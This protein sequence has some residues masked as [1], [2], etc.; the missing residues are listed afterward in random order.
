MKHVFAFLAILLPASL[1]TLAAAEYAAPV[2]PLPYTAEELLSTRVR[3]TYEGDNLNLVAFPLGGIGA[4]CISLAGTGKLVD[5]E[6]F[7]QPNKG[8]QPRFSFLSVWAKSE[9]GQP[10]FKVLEGQLR[11]RLDGPVYLAK[12][13][14]SAGHGIG[15][16]QTQ[17]A[18]LPRMRQCTFIGRFPY[19]RVELSDPALPLAATIE[20]WSP[21]IPGN[22]RESSLPVA[23][24]SV[25][26]RNTSTQ[27]VEFA[28]AANVQNRAGTINEIVREDRFSALVMRDEPR[29][30]DASSMALAIPRQCDMWQRNW[31]P[32][33]NFMSLQHFVDTF[34]LQGRM[35]CSEPGSDLAGRAI[36]GAR[37]DVVFDDFEDG[38]YGKWQAQGEAFGNRP[39]RTNEFHHQQ[40]VGGTQ[41][42][43]FV[44]SF[45]NN[46][47][48]DAGVSDRVVGELVSKP[49]TINRS[50]LRFLIGGGADETSVGLRLLVDGK[51]VRSAAGHNSELLA[52]KLWD[53]QEFAGREAVLQIVDRSSGGWGHVLVDEIVL[54]DSSELPGRASDLGAGSPTENENAQVG[55]LGVRRVLAPGESFTLPMLVAWYFPKGP[56]WRN[57]YATQWKDAQDVARYVATNLNRLDAETR[58]FQQTFFDSTLPGTVLEAVSS[59]LA[60]L[61]SPTVIRLEDG[62]LYGWEGCAVNYRLGLGTVNHVW[63][64][65]Q[66]VP[67]LFPDLQRSIIENFWN[68]GVDER[69]K[70]AYRIPTRPGDKGTTRDAADGRNDATGAFPNFRTTHAAADGQFGQICWVYREW[71][72]SGDAA[73]L[74]RMWPT[75]KKALEY[76]WAVWDT[77]RDG[78]LDGSH[79]NTLDLN[80]SSPETMCGSL[81]QAAL[82]AGEKMAL[83][84]GDE[85]AAG[86]YRRVFE[87]GKRNSDEKLFNG[88][89]YQQMLPAPGDYQVGAGC[90]SEQVH[91]QLYAQM[92]GLEDIYDRSHIHSALGSLFKYNYCDN[93]HD[94]LN[95]NRAYAINEDRGLL[96]ATWPRGGKPVH[97]L[98]Y[99]DETQIGYEYQVAGNLLYE[100]YL[101]E[102]LTVIRSIR[103]RFDGK[104]RNP[105][106][107]FE[108]GNHY[109][110]SMANYNALLALSG[111]RTDAPRRRIEFAP[112]VT[113]ENF[114]GFFAAGD[115]WGSY[116]QRA[117][118]GKFSARLEM[119]SGTLRLN[120]ISLVAPA[121]VLEKAVVTAAGQ[122]LS[123]RL[124]IQNGK[125][126]VTLEHE[127]IIP[128][129]AALKITLPSK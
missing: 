9:G 33:H 1:V 28:L 96:I 30:P 63:N 68:H 16:Q 37:P 62:T 22:S 88:E 74:K 65:Q 91:G 67:Y 108:W 18:G 43:H 24:L 104:R 12:G 45:R 84:L 99:C 77:D 15:P 97:P 86:E 115:G 60:I 73:W 41:G 36:A 40:P 100:G 55:S 7:N 90:L 89:Y 75:T 44:D 129:G 11:E 114:K 4:G 19:A 94:R 34:A 120:E 48:A 103:D 50:H 109:A 38:T 126:V 66:A 119:K 52:S 29:P 57:Y 5:W 70:V 14:T 79:H 49:F 123:H 23:V 80:F 127:L 13:M 8:Y 25:T 106:C 26:L 35:D 116:S 81:Y 59:Q 101:L 110:R 92:L 122:Q 61:R 71:R 95:A 64:Y 32:G 112:R 20:G 117:A 17:A 10:V 21:F 118:N 27:R 98:L 85:A 78:L 121:G 82:L 87:L 6:I 53:V 69:G 72:I 113:P 47:P 46:G 128:A 76:A 3:D 54:T 124:A 102:G 58:A 125:A 107:E 31:K 105:F 39:A 83:A 93:F 42:K 2:K 111:F 56:T 51:T